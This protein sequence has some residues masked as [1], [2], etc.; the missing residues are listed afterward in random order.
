MVPACRLSPSSINRGGAMLNEVSCWHVDWSLIGTWVGGIGSA[1]AATVAVFISRNDAK[2][3]KKYSKFLLNLDLERLSNLQGP[4]E[5]MIESLRAYP[6]AAEVEQSHLR[7]LGEVGFKA[8]HQLPSNL[9]FFGRSERLFEYGN[10]SSAF[11]ELNSSVNAILGLAD[12]VSWYV[13]HI[14]EDAAAD[15]IRETLDRFGLALKKFSEE[16]AHIR[17]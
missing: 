8:L 15:V 6:F 3:R 1:A 9:E 14:D 5:Q 2:R 11:E 12:L 16:N 13:D 7:D 17:L 4:L 10:G